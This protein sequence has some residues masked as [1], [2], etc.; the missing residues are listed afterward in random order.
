MEALGKVRRDVWREAY[1]E[2]NALAKEYPQSRH[3]INGF[4][5]QVTARSRRYTS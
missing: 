5:G 3:W 1:A 4:G 2:A